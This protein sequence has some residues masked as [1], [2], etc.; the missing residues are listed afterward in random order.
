MRYFFWALV[1]IL[2]AGACASSDAPQTNPG[3]GCAINSDCSTPLVCAFRKCHTACLDTR[4]CPTNQ[5]CMA[6]DRP[7]HV[8]QLPTETKCGYNSDCPEG[9][10]CAVD[11]QCRDQCTSDRDCVSHQICTA[12]S[13][14]EVV[15]LDAGALT[16]V[17]VTEESG[18]PS[19]GQPCQYTSD[20]PTN[21]ICRS[22]GL[23]APE[24]VTSRDCAAGYACQ[25]GGCKF[26][27]GV[28]GTGGGSAQDGS[29]TPG[30]DAAVGGTC[31]NMVKD[32]TETDVDCG[33][34]S[35]PPCATG[36][37]C[38]GAKDCASGK[39]DSLVC[40][41]PTCSDTIKNGS[42]TA[43]DCGGTCDPC[44][45]GKT[46]G[47]GTDCA[48]GLC[49]GSTCHALDCTDG[50]RDGDETDVDCGGGT[51]PKCD[52][53]KACGGNADCKNDFCS[54]NVCQA[55]GCNDGRK[56][57][58]ETDVDCGGAECKKCAAS[59]ACA[60]AG[61]CATGVC[62]SLICQSSKCDDHVKNGNESDVDC[63]GGGCAACAAGLKCV[64][65]TDC[66][67]NACGVGVCKATF[68][69][70]IVLGRRRK[71]SRHVHARGNRL[72]GQVHGRFPSRERS[73]A[74][75]RAE[76]ELDVYRLDRRRVHR[77]E[78]VPG[79]HESAQSVPLR[80][81]RELPV[82]S[83]GRRS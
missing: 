78:H 15:E 80:S 57:G 30:P 9:Q 39:C 1:T 60:L 28:T 49:I 2:L 62:T 76:P 55:T 20:C 42:E 22:S 33:G 29:V 7:F 51:C 64:R 74:Q 70:T 26:E 73:A 77:N 67:S 16:P 46:C 48:T 27:G 56:S 11:G 19:N 50:L 23:C 81:R 12:R 4:D 8:C 47:K 52:N 82:R 54:A 37:G 18:A 24:C 21:R 17:V 58:T 72:R 43:V 14:A 32:G 35:C 6:S 53:Q 41:M 5:R 25:A 3:D 71:W 63:G 40:Q 38:T 45:N 69:L 59:Q 83:T 44:A 61:D 66:A 13:C 65:N 34:G 79:D 68:P 10:I 36:G 75:R 31:A